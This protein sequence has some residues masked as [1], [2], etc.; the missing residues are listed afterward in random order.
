MEIVLSKIFNQIIIVVHLVLNALPCGRKF[1]FD[2]IVADIVERK[3]FEESNIFIYSH[4]PN[5]YVEPEQV[6]F[7]PYILWWEGE[8]M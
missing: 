6:K 3:F 8:G 2:I 4:L 7:Q 5:E 1:L